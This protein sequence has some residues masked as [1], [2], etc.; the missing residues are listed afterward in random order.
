MAAQHMQ[1][2]NHSSSTGQPITTRLVQVVP[3]PASVIKTVSE[4]AQTEEVQMQVC[5]QNAISKEMNI[6]DGYLKVAVLMLRWDR[7]LDQFQEHD[8]EVR[9]SLLET[10]FNVG[11]LI[12][13]RL[14]SS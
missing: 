1:T 2:T 4:E 7:S 13:C 5:F 8:R 6:P 3:D 14:K 10:R 11:R 9:G 12:W